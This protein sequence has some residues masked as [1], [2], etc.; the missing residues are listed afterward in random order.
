MKPTTA[1]EVFDLMDAYVTSAA[2]NAALELGLFW[3]LAEQPL[4]APAVAEALRIPPCRC[5][6]WLQLLDTTGLI[7]QGPDGYAASATAQTAILG[8][9]SQDTW[10]LLAQDARD[11]YPAILDL[12]LHMREPGS[13]WAAQGLTPPDYFAQMIESPER[14]DRFT[15]ML[16]EIHLPLAEALAESLDMSGV[17]RMMDLGGGSGVLSMALLRRCPDLTAVV[18]DIANVC[19]AGRRIA[20]EESM[21]T[22]LTYHAADFLHDELPFGFDLILDCDVGAYSEP[23]LQKIRAALVPGGRLVIVHQFAPRPEV[24]PATPP[25]PVWAFLASLETTDLRYTTTAEVQAR[26]RRVGFRRLSE[27]VLPQRGT[28]RWTQGWT[29]I[30]AWK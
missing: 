3:L 28:L 19:A 24:A 15:R 10:A 8:A 23:M 17:R 16:Y 4:E 13:T 7:E 30:E 14:A 29:M 2:L 20:Q 18:V 22:R 21:E 12:T 11:R 27:A 26:L 1:D 25:R 9:C 6:H 5:R